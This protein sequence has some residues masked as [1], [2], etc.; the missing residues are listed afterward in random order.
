MTEAVSVLDSLVQEGLSD[1]VTF[2]FFGLFAFFRATPAAYGG[3]QARGPIGGVATGLCQ[4]H[5]NLG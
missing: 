2:F 1:M 3:S 5:S 4:S